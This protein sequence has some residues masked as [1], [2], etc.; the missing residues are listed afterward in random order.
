MIQVVSYDSDRHEPGWRRLAA[1]SRSAWPY[2]TRQWAQVLQ[3]VFML[4]EESLVCE[5]DSEVVGILPLWR[6]RG[7]TLVNA[8]WRDRA[9]FL[10]RGE[11]E[12]L[13]YL[14]ARKEKVILKDCDA[15]DVLGAC[16]ASY[17]V[18]TRLDLGPGK[19]AIW[20]VINRTTGR[21]IRKA[22]KSGVAIEECCDAEGL[23]LFYSLFATTRKRLGVPIYP[24]RL[25]QQLS[26]RLAK[27]TFRLYLAKIGGR[28]VAGAIILDSP[29][30]A[31][32]AYGA[33]D[34]VYQRT[35]AFDLLIWRAI[36]KT[37]EKG[38][39]C[40]DFGADSPN[41]SS[42]LRF[43]SKWGGHQQ[44][45]PT[46]LFRMNPRELHASDFASPKYRMHRAILR[47]MP[48][49]LLVQAGTWASRHG[50]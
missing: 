26:A 34:M 35:R 19:N 14:G 46:L 30:G 3:D 33:S 5:E 1:Q 50:G 32:Y 12:A 9:G 25:F 36:E 49:S 24:L 31:V 10:G 20:K 41:Q 37:L 27:E 2:H 13:H 42:L 38:L 44:I 22:E 43:K 8:P 18:T 39:P 47:H 23:R 11:R 4:K 48:K 21:N 6:T 40:F 45:L 28:A 7:D 16:K 15:D 17:W 29:A